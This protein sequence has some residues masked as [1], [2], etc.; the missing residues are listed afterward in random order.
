MLRPL[1]LSAALFLAPAAFAEP[2]P[3]LVKLDASLARIQED[4]KQGRL[5]PNAYEDALAAFRSELAAAVSEVEPSSDNAALHARIL[6]RLADPKSAFEALGPALAREPDDAG[7]RVALS[8]VLL[9]Q[10]NYPAALAE[11]NAVLER[12]PLNKAALAIKFEAQGRA[13]PSGAA[14]QAQTSAAGAS[15]AAPVVS[16]KPRAA[17][18]TIVPLDSSEPSAPVP[19][20]GGLPLWPILP[21][22]GLGAAAFV[23]RRSRATVESEDGFNEDDRPQPGRLQEFVAGAVLAG[24]AG[25]AIYLGGVYIVGAA[26]TGPGQQALRLAQSQTGAINPGRT[27]AVNE[28][29]KILARVIPFPDGSKVPD[30]IGKFGDTKVFVTAAEDIVGLNAQQLSTRA[31]PIKHASG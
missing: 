3:Q 12:D 5:E 18:T 26:M 27:K 16:A 17:R 15:A 23:V 29:P 1:V 7:L 20:S 11:A 8:Q 19:E 10:K 13:E 25:A 9:E 31:T 14:T 4:H 30:N 22:A 28:V 6:S 24:M 21:A 2:A